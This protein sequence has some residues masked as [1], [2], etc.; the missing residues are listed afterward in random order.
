M[1]V[2]IPAHPKDFDVLPHAVRGVMRH[3]RNRGRVFV[4]GPED[5]GLRGVT[6]IDEDACPAGF[7]S[8]DDVRAALTQGGGDGTRAGWV[9]QQ[10]LKL[11]VD[12]LVEGLTQKYLVIDSD[13]IFLRT[14][15][16]GGIRFPYSIATEYQQQYLDVCERL[17]GEPVGTH[18]FTAHHM[19]FDRELASELRAELERRHGQP[20]WRAILASLDPAEASAFSEWNLYGHWVLAR[21]RDDASHRQLFWLDVRNVPTAVGRATLGMYHD[22]VAAHSYRREQRTDQAR[23]FSARLARELQHSI[24]RVR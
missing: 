19:A 10:L 15:D 12:E 6:W 23:V 17:I 11:G 24:G 16:F 2:V 13:V 3:V 7:P 1:D 8:V 18:S 22:F 14:V 21:H 20:W 4:V 9:Y 5:P